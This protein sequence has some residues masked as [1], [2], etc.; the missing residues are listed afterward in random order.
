MVNF[1]LPNVAE[2]YIHR[3]GRTGRAG[4]TGQA[5]SLVCAEE[6]EDLVGIQR[7]IGE[8]L[9]REVIEGFEPVEI[10]PKTTDLRPP[11]KK[12]PNRSSGQSKRRDDQ[13]SNKNVEDNKFIG[14]NHRNTTSVTK[15]RNTNTE[16]SSQVK[17]HSQNKNHHNSNRVNSNNGNRRSPIRDVNGNR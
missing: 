10:L 14:K 8:L 1:D 13:R 3:I 11:K 5:V 7:L 12:R 2:D 9:E 4:S 16:E 15:V 6:L 17:N